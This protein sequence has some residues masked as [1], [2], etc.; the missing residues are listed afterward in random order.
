MFSV[1]FGNDFAVYDMKKCVDFIARI[2]LISVLYL[3]EFYCLNDRF[4]MPEILYVCGLFWTAASNYAGQLFVV[5]GNVSVLTEH[6]RICIIHCF[7]M[8][9][10]VTMTSCLYAN[11]AAWFSVVMMKRRTVMDLM[12]TSQ[13]LLL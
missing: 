8:M 2:N 7:R 1:N 4:L 13:Q 9:R 10:T 6:T 12:T 11:I 3:N 5:V